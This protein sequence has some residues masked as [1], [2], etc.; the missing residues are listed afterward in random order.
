[1]AKQTLQPIGLDHGVEMA[2]SCLEAGARLSLPAKIIGVAK[3]LAD[4]LQGRR[5][6][7]AVE[8]SIPRQS[9]EDERRLEFERFIH[10]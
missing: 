4:F 1:M 8:S 2:L 6:R 3:A 5:L 7:A 9:H 10:W